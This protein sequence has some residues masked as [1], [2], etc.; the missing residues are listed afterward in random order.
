MAL[1]APAS[2][3]AEGRVEAAADLL[4]SWGLRVHVGPAARAVGQPPHA[5]LAGPD[6]A[7][8]ADFVEAMT[9]PGV[10]AVVCARGGTGVGRLLEHLTSADWLAMAEAT[11]RWLV[12]SSD[13]TGLHLALAARGL[14]CSV[15]GPMPASDAVVGNGADPHSREQLRPSLFEPTAAGVLSG[16]VGVGGAAVTAP[17]VGGTITVI[18]SLLATPD[19]GSA[20]GHI[21]LLEDVDEAPRRLDRSLTHLRRSGWLDGVAGVVVGSLERCGGAATEIVLDRVG[22]LG[23]PVLTDLEVGHGPRQSFLPLGLPARLDPAT[24][25]LSWPTSPPAP[26]GAAPLAE[27]G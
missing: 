20:R 26:S 24:A 5:H 12:G 3:V 15:F 11:P 6:A 9:R 18:E 4:T 27:R 23:I 21:V 25:T 17:V 19:I 1:I 13:I 7:R 2:P 14:P 22:D 16:R 8:R 10:A